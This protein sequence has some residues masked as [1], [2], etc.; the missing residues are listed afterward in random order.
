MIEMEGE[1][2]SR[3]LRRRIRGMDAIV[4]RGGGGGRNIY[5]SCSKEAMFHLLIHTHTHMQNERERG[6]DKTARRKE[7]IKRRASKA[8]Q[9]HVCVRERGE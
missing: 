7:R 2:G 6:R 8:K 3:L 5:V 9:S 1:G 4:R